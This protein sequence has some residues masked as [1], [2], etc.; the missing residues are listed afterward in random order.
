MNNPYQ[1]LSK[2]S[3]RMMLIS[4]IG[5]LGAISLGTLVWPSCERD[6]N[7][8]VWSIQMLLLLPFLPSML[9]QKLRT[10]IWL[11][12]ILLGF[13]MTSV[14]TAFACPNVLA[15]SEVMLTV[16]LFISIMMYVRWRAR[17]MKFKNSELQT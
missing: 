15:I 5:L 12:F 8:V 6:P 1:S 14:T 9:S 11:T 13:F 17:E 10:L 16:V 3:R 4:F 7:A 2:N